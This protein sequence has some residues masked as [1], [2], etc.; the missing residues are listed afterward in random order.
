[1]HVYLYIYIYIYTYLDRKTATRAKSR[2]TCM[3]LKRFHSPGQISTATNRRHIRIYHALF[4][5]AASTAEDTISLRLGPLYYLYVI[6]AYLP[7]S[8]NILVL[9]DP[10]YLVGRAAPRQ[11]P[12]STHE[13]I[14]HIIEA[15]MI[16]HTE[17]RDHLDL[18]GREALRTEVSKSL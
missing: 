12:L 1:M 8:R 2:R 3:D 10:Y 11:K 9:H 15:L 5:C 6:E 16:G 4:F 7:S 14:G 17:E 18:C 13:E